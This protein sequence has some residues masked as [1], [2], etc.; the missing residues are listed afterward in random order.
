MKFY[1]SYLIFFIFIIANKFFLFN[2]EFLILICFVAFCFTMYNKLSFSLQARFDEKI[3]SDKFL[4]IES[5]LKIEDNLK[6]KYFLNKKIKKFKNLFFLLKNYYKNL[7]N[8]FL[9]DFLSYMNNL[10]K[11]NINN[12]LFIIKLIEVEYSKFVFLLINKKINS[13]SKLI[14]FLNNTLLIKKFKIINKI[15]K[16]SILKKI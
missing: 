5:L 9:I 16:L 11:T 7:T 12:K 14:F 8:K 4:I 13:L 15:N 1:F 10:E 2:E 6:H 3:N